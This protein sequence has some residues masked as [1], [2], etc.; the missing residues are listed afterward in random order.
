MS[1]AIATASWN[2]YWERFGKEFSA[3]LEDMNPW[4]DEVIVVANHELDAPHWVRQVRAR[5]LMPMWDWFNE[6]VEACQSEWVICPGADDTFMPCALC[7]LDLGGDVLAIAGNENGELWCAEEDE[8]QLMLDLPHNPMKGGVIFRRDVFLRFPWRRVCW[9][10]WAQWLEFRH[11]GLD[12]R[13][14]STARFVHR[15][16]DGAHSMKPTERGDVEIA[17]LKNKLRETV[18]Q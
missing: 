3:S 14:D 8:Y 12:V 18:T 9:P 15:R 13:F 1:I 5:S 11:A 17:E 10:D 2:G 16:F 7:D 6:A 4:A